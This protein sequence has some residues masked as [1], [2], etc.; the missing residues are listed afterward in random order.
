VAKKSS[1]KS[2]DALKEAAREIGS[3]LG[4]VHVK[5][6]RVVEGVKAAVKAGTDTY[7][8]KPLAKKRPSKAKKK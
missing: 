2:G 8:G 5:A 7:K 3:R 6:S 4:E 1:S